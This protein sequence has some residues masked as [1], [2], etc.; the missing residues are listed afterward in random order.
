MKDWILK[1]TIHYFAYFFCLII[2]E[3]GHV[4]F[5]IIFGY[6]PTKLKFG[7]R[8]VIKFRLLKTHITIGLIPI[9]GFNEIKINLNE[10]DYIRLDNGLIVVPH[11]NMSLQKLKNFLIK[12]GGCLFNLLTYFTILLFNKFGY[13]QDTF[14]YSVKRISLTA[15]FL[16]FIFE[17]LLNKQIKNKIKNF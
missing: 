5:S 2:H 6:Y 10:N 9:F 3:L 7:L 14:F 11:N 15:F 4:F 1:I 8:E 17:I 13:L 16:L 12:I